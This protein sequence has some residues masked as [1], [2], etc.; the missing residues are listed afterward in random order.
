[1]S[2]TVF[3]TQMVLINTDVIDLISRERNVTSKEQNA[4]CDTKY[5]GLSVKS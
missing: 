3:C 1:M 4:V 2:G 5:R